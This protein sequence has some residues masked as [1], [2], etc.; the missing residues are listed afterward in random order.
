MAEREVRENCVREKLERWGLLSGER[1]KRSWVKYK[2]LLK[3]LN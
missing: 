2:F 3:V 1:T